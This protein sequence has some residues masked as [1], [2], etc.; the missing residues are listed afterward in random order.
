MWFG[1]LSFIWIAVLVVLFFINMGKKI[2]ERNDELTSRQ[3]LIGAFISLIGAAI[4]A[5]LL[6]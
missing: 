5:W 1:I 3:K 6:S 4:V 2:V